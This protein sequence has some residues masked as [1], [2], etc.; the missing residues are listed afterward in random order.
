MNQF[1]KAVLFINGC[2]P[3][4]F[5]NIITYSLVG[6]TDGAFHYLNKYQSMLDFIIGDLDSINKIIINNSSKFLI[7][8]DQNKT[9]FEKAL[10]YLLER[11]IEQVDVFGAT[12]LEQD[13]FLGNIS[14]AM[15]FFKK[16]HITFFDSFGSFFF[17]KKQSQHKVRKG[18]NISLIPI[19][20]VKKIITTGLMYQLNSSNLEFGNLIGIRNQS[21]EENINI[22]FKKGKLLLFI[23]K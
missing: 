21:I 18:A 11:N 16:I 1:K 12:G 14:V 4:D 2:P 3:Q 23:G 5:P 19:K 7:R 8:E 17:V 13:H 6:C 10:E 9:D 20:K 15:K 22:S